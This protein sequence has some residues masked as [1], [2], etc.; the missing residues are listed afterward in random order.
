MPPKNQNEIFSKTETNIKILKEK[1]QKEKLFFP[2]KKN[3]ES[4]VDT[5]QGIGMDIFKPTSYSIILNFNF[6]KDK[7]VFKIKDLNKEMKKLLR[8]MGLKKKDL[9]NVEMVLNFFK[10]LIEKCD[11]FQRQQKIIDYELVEAKR[12][13]IFKQSV[14][15]SIIKYRIQEV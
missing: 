5:Y 2:I 13:L 3:F 7:K 12:T 4:L 10:T 8:Y 11:K 15:I 14:N 6:D 9:G 1:L